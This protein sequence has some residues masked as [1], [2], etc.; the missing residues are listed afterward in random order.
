MHKMQMNHTRHK[1]WTKTCKM[2]LNGFKEI[3]RDHKAMQNNYRGR[4]KLQPWHT[5]LHKTE[6]NQ[7][8]SSALQLFT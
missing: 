7:L 6:K 3:Q 8:L 4:Q 5:E 2:I 1:M